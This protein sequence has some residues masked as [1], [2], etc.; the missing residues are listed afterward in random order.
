MP[1]TT[2]D[3]STVLV[4]LMKGVTYRDAA[5][6]VWQSLVA[7]APRVRDYVQLLGLELVLDEAEGY[8]YL[9]QRPAVEGETEIPRLVVRRQL[10]YQLSLL[11]VLLR[12]KLAEFDAQ[13]GDT[14]LVLS[15]DEIVDLVRVFLPDSAN[16][17]RLLDR[18]DSQINKVIELGFLRRLRGRDDQFEVQRIL[19]AFVDAQWLG[20]LE[21]RLVDYRAHVAQDDAS[22]EDD[23]R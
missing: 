16:E 13:S 11:L 9:R 23:A 6:D 15:R 10:G 19:K 2:P 21:S 22:R 12:K 17:A 1:E 4:T 8:A 3:L 7:A 18:I 20:D 5:P 14:R